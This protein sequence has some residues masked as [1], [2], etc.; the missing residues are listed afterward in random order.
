M[1]LILFDK[2][3]GEGTPEECRNRK[4]EILKKLRDLGKALKETPD[5]G[6]SQ[7]TFETLESINPT[8]YEILRYFKELIGENFIEYQFLRMGLPGVVAWVRDASSTNKKW[9]HIL[10]HIFL[11]ILTDNSPQKVWRIEE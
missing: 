9:G 6:D 3:V 1:K 2:V 8:A 5:E 4:K 7:V 10:G 11:Q